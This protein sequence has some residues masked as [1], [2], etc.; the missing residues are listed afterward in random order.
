MIEQLKQATTQEERMALFQS[1]DFQQA[2]A[3]PHEYS[4]RLAEDGSFKSDAIPAGKYEMAVDFSKP[5]P[6]F[7]PEDAQ[8]FMSPQQLIVP[9]AASTNDDSVVDLGTIELKQLSLADFQIKQK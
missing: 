8:A 4:L 1:E 9:P 7:R 5:S 3:N 2:M 6:A